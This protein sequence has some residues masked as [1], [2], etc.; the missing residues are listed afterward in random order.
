MNQNLEQCETINFDDIILFSVQSF[1]HTA[2]HCDCTVNMKLFSP[3]AN[4][5]TLRIYTNITQLNTL[6]K[7]ALFFFKKHGHSDFSGSLH[8]DPMMTAKMLDLHLKL[9]VKQ[10][11]CFWKK[12]SAYLC[13]VFSCVIFV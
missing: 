1:L 3:Y 8:S 13:Y 7:Y 10:V 11:S 2:V 12:N 9:T 5:H 4:T 6:H